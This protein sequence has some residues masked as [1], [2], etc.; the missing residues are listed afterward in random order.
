VGKSPESSNAPPWRAPGCGAPSR[1]PIFFW[2]L[3]VLSGWIPFSV[4]GAQS[5]SGFSPTFGAPGAQVTITAG[6]GTVFNTATQV[7]FNQTPADFQIQS[8]T[9]IIATVPTNASSGPITVQVGST[10]IVSHDL[11]AL[12]PRIDSFSPLVAGVGTDVSIFGANFTF[13][14]LVAVSSVRFGGV[15]STVVSVTSDSQIQA[16]VPSG[17]LTGPITVSTFA[18][19]NS[20]RTNFVVN[21]AG[22]V[23]TGF[24]PS[25]GS[26]NTEVIIDGG[27]FTSASAV[28]FNGTNASF[29]VTAPSQ[30]HAF[31][32]ALATTGLIR[33]T[34][35]GGTAASSSNFVVTGKAPIITGFSPFAGKPG[36]PVVLEGVNFITVTNVSFN[37]VN[38]TN[39]AATSDTQI[40]AI[41]PPGTS[42]GLISARNAA[43]VGLSPSNFLVGPVIT[44]FAPASGA[45]NS[46]VNISGENFIGATFVKFGSFN[47]AFSVVA[48]N[49]ITATVPAGAT[50]APITVASSAG[51]NTTASN[52]VV[53]ASAPLITGFTPANGVPGQQV[54]ITGANFAGATNVSFNGVRDTTFTAPTSDSQLIATVPTGATTGPIQI[55][56]PGGVGTSSNLFYLAPRLTGFS[57]SSGV[58]GTMVIITGASFDDTALVEFSGTNATR[59][60]A[61]FT[62]SA[63]QIGAIV[64]TFAAT[65][66]IT[67]TTPGGVITST[68]G[69]VVL[70]KITSFSPAI[71]P[72]GT[73][74]T[75]TGTGFYSVT[76]VRFNGINA[77]FTTD[78]PTQI[79]ATV[80]NGAS[81]GPIT[82]VTPDGTATSPIVFTVTISAD[83]SLTLTQPSPFVAFS[84]NWSYI[85]TVSNL[86]PSIATKV[87]VSD[88]LPTGVTLV[89][90][91]LTQGTYSVT[92]G[93]VTLK[94]GTISNGFSASATL[95]VSATSPEVYENFASVA[96]AESDPVAGNNAGD[97]LT[98]VLSEAERTL[99]IRKLTGSPQVEIS[100]PHLTPLNLTLQSTPSLSPVIV[101]TDLTNPPP[102]LVTNSSSILNV[103]NRDA[104]TGNSFFRLKGQ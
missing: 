16:R 59:V 35:P 5:I 82:V 28:T 29:S 80:P 98:Q 27:D 104:S 90:A 73:V 62:N 23:I 8:A 13:S 102:R 60:S 55:F 69:F 95:I 58:S 78:S 77:S 87:T 61:A 99:A 30:I 70:P 15:A 44:G 11:F 40:T 20:S 53:L 84:N 38:A 4:R 49:Q 92:N 67:V 97:L 39:F 10:T 94:F 2:L 83:L 85:L 42:S 100:W 36:D 93:V 81:T 31:V 14:N 89:T 6:S 48:Q 17:A 66:P 71:G 56:G 51:T 21:G 101:W 63:T 3:I 34:T 7:T 46:Q 52:F 19:T 25:S 88:T 74:V 72:V 9:Q 41:V 57:P 1:R 47:A 103:V 65:G 54:E 22:S 24:T 12:A 91:V 18:G 96:S 68:N 75:I 86:G 50:N 76:E 33:V 26:T 64:P 37:G 43:G 79:T 45:V 32:P